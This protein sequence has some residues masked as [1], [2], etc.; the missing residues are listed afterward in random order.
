MKAHAAHPAV[1]NHQRGAALLV[2]LLGVGLLAAYFALGL[3]NGPNAPRERQRQAANRLSDAKQA[4]IGFAATYRD[5]HADEPFGFLPCPDSNNDGLANDTPCA[6]AG[7]SLEGRLPWRHLA[8]PALRDADGECLWYALS[9]I[10]KDNPKTTP[11]NWDSL[12]QYVVRDFSGT[13][14]TG[15]TPHERPLAIV[16][17]AGQT[18]AAQTRAGGAG[19]CGGS[20]NTAD[21]FEGIAPPVAGITT[22]TLANDASI[23]NG[24]NNDRGL[25]LSSNE[26]FSRVMRRTDFAEDINVLLNDLSVCL[27][28]LPPASL[29]ATT[30]PNPGNKGMDNVFASCPNTGSTRRINVRNHWWNN[31]LYARPATPASITTGSST[32]TGCQAVLIFG[33]RRATGQNRT[34]A[35]ETG[36]ATTFG[37]PAMYLEGINATTYPNSG[38][39]NGLASFDATQPSSDV[40]RCIKGLPTGAS[41]VSF[42]NASDFASFATAGSGVSTDT[43]VPGAP[44]VIINDA[45]GTSGG[46]FWYPTPLTLAGRVLRLHYRYQFAFADPTGGADRG[47]GFTVQLVRS[48]AGSPAA[49]CGTEANMGVLDLSD[50]RGNLSFI[51][52][53]DVYRNAGHTDPAENHTAILAH[54][55]LTHSPTNGNTTT[56][57]NGSAAGCSHTPAD[58][59]E[60]SA[61]PLIRDQ[62]IEIHT[63]CN[64][65]CAT[66]NPASHAAPNT[67]ARISVWASCTGCGDVASDLDRTTAPPTANRCINLNTAMNSSYFG[68]TAGMRSGASQQ[69]VTLTDLTLRSE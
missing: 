3:L 21:Y 59:L 2:I 60:E 52:E 22:V 47:N 27:N 29:P 6:A 15:A 24:N 69:G 53:T 33:G 17:A 41:Q 12:G 19:E 45:A 30:T 16:L 34:I 48:D 26:V 67:Y 28:N 57:C 42:S 10:A 65:T 40:L 37:N 64:A 1:A 61:T 50:V 18:L 32:T 63:G 11:F 13:L 51:I 56:A 7:V 23:A 14:L 62:R 8:L 5:S 54:G 31:L 68:F 38:N 25:W 4:L 39:Y 44:R 35:A 58:R 49:T 55:N 66:C 20:L 46:C 43:S 9:G 36:N